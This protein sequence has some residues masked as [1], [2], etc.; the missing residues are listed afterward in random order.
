MPGWKR[1][2]VAH[3]AATLTAWAMAIGPAGAEPVGFRA[4]VDVTVKQLDGTVVLQRGGAGAPPVVTTNTPFY[5]ETFNP[6][7]VKRTA[8]GA[9]SSEVTMG[10]QADVKAR[11]LG[12]EVK[13]KETLN[14]FNPQIASQLPTAS[15]QLSSDAVLRVQVHDRV[16]VAVD[17]SEPGQLVEMSFA[18]M[19]I[20]GVLDTPLFGNGSAGVTTQLTIVPLRG[21]PA[22]AQ[23]PPFD[24][25]L[26]AGETG[27]W[28]NASHEFGSVLLV[29][30]GEYEW[31]WELRVVAGL[32]MAEVSLDGS[33]SAT[34]STAQS[35]FLHTAYWGGV[36][37]VT[38]ADGKPLDGLRLTSELGWDWTS[39]R[40]STVPEPAGM[41]LVAL[42]AAGVARRAGRDRAITPR[43]AAPPRP[44]ARG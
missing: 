29:N 37:S 2:A 6:I 35:D 3:A 24:A 7:E 34:E 11:S 14:A 26:D 9:A 20:W 17:E 1:A 19:K 43:R 22:P 4:F 5:A 31:T 21:L 32:S 36:R 38:D 18:D 13:V 23:L 44:A 8:P 27:R 12:A 41:V 33:G 30:G 16:R 15:K 28:A 10:T 39:T 25:H 40:A 42:V